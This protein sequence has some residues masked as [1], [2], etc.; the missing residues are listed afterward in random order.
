M[1]ELI[2]VGLDTLYFVSSYLRNIVTYEIIKPNRE[3][4][5]RVPVLV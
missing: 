1:D 3:I 2:N 4:L 5:F